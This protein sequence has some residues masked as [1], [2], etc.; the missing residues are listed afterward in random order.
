[1]EVFQ[2]LSILFFTYSFLGWV[3]E[4]IVV[5][6]V[7]KKLCDRGFLIGPICPIYGISCVV[8]TILIEKYKND[9]LVLFGMSM[10][11]C[12]LFEYVTSYIM[13]KLFKTRWWDYSHCKFNLNGRVCLKNS[14]IFGILGLLVIVV[15]NPF[16]F[17]LFSSIQIN[18]LNIILI[19]L[20]M[21]FTIDIIISFSV[22]CK[23]KVETDHL[24]K[25]CT[26]EINEKI[27]KFIKKQSFL[28]K[29]L[30]KAFPNFKLISKIKNKNDRVKH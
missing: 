9:Y 30:F 6:I 22:M 21:V 12:T 1:M 16:F 20:F 23:I 14:I 17:N 7:N 28:Y 24:K 13:E 15:L 4:I 8:I 27:R 19:V 5:S 2:K 3:M 10:L 29:R 18:I 26:E 11:I 25:D